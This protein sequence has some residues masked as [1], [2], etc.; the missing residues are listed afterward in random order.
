R[1]EK[2]PCDTGSARLLPKQPRLDVIRH[3]P[4]S[5]ILDLLAIDR[6]HAV[7]DVAH[8]R[9]HGHWIFGAVPDGLR[10]VAQPIESAWNPGTLLDL[11]EMLRNRVVRVV[12]SLPVVHHKESLLSLGL[13]PVSPSQ[14]SL[15]GLNS[16]RP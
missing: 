13:G 2:K 4:Q 16:L 1:A 8:D 3:G 15:E 5:A 9:L 12:P 10:G 11:S 6:A 7:I 14:R